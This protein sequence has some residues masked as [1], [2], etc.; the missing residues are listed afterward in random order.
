MECHSI[1]DHMEEEHLSSFIMSWIQNWQAPSIPLDD[2]DVAFNTVTPRSVFVKNLRVG[3]RLL[4]IGAG[5]GTL[6]VYRTWPLFPRLDIKMYALSLTKGEH[7]DDY[8]AYELKNLQETDDV[9][10]NID[11]QAFVCCHFIEHMSDPRRTV[12]FFRRRLRPGGRV[13]LEWPHPISKR[14][15]S[16]TA[17]INKGIQVSTIR[18]DDDAT[19][20]E[21][22]AM[23]ELSTILRENGFAIETAGR[24]YFPFLADELRNHGCMKSD[25]VR[26]TL[27]VWA[28]VGWAQYLVAV[29]QY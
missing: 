23:P 1:Y 25:P 12:E 24:T 13:Y 9:F 11:V 2:V 16:R 26:T 4:D 7:F 8:D 5:D 10:V 29:K 17:F 3:A 21:A 6:S 15:P 19:H 28:F 14:M 27:A 22:W 18:F 20:I